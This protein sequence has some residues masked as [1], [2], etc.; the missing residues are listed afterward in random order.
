MLKLGVS[1]RQAYVTMVTGGR[2]LVKVKNRLPGIVPSGIKCEAP[3]Q[4]VRLQV[5]DDA[6]PRPYTPRHSPGQGSMEIPDLRVL[7]IES[8]VLH[9]HADEKRVARLQARVQSD[10]FLK[11]PPIVAPI[12][13]T[14]LF[15]VLDG[16]NRTSA[17][18]GL[19]FPHILAQ[20]VDYRSNVQLVTWYHLIAGREPSAFL[21]EIATIEGL[22]LQ[23]VP[24]ELAREALGR[25]V[26]LAYIVIPAPNGSVVFGV[27]GAPGTDHH[28]THGS[29]ALLN[30]MVDT[31]KG[32]PQ[33][34]IH[35]VS[36][37]ELGELMSYYDNVSG[38]VVFPPY[39]TDDILKLAEAGTKVPT[40]ITR[41]IIDHRALRVNAPLSL[42][43]SDDPLE[44]KNAWW[45]EQVKRKLAA[46][47]IRLYQESTYLFDE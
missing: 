1:V 19:G 33:V 10:G 20:V 18:K 23:Q 29:T 27:D 22:V 39:S 43:S 37:D 5:P 13:G 25:R 8:L 4:E 12:P 3:I 41:H 34:A 30:A 44:E 40:G 26:I 16:A 17:I 47:E 2:P 42:L 38:L 32:D 36:T 35:R 24:I 46:N 14:Q 6:P 7:P 45:H 21:G 28:G 15:V 11:N 9:E 31:Y